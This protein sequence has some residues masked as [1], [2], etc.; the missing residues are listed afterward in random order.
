MKNFTFVKGILAFTILLVVSTE[1]AASQCQFPNPIPFYSQNFGTGA[2]P[3]VSPL[4]EYQVPELT[5]V[6][7]GNMNPEKI[8]TIS[9]TTNHH[10]PAS[11]WHIIADHTGNTQGRMMLVNDREPAGITYRDRLPS[12]ALGQGNLYFLSAWVMNILKPGICTANGNNPDIFISL[13]VDTKLGGVWSSLVTS[14]I[15]TY[16]S[17]VAPVWNRIGV[18]FTTPAG[19]YDSLRISINNESVVLCGNDYVVD[20]ISIVGC[21]GNIILPVKLLNFS[22]TLKNDVTT[23]NWETA[24]EVNFSHYE[25]E[26]RNANS[27]SYATVGT[28][29]LANSNG[30]AAYNFQDNLSGVSGDVFFYRLRM[31]DLDGSAEYSKEI[32]VRRGGKAL[33]GIA[34][35]PNPVMNGGAASV[36]FEAQR[37]ALVTLRVIDGTGKT[38]LQQ[39]NKV[40]EGTNSL[41]V[42]NIERLQPGIY[43]VQLSVG[44]ELSAVK[45]TV[46]R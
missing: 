33:S 25:I 18:N 27:G 14:P 37:S 15:F 29:A 32:L 44:D 30:R 3:A 35:N 36:R 43:V 38:V 2:R 20:D 46:V 16:P 10:S 7:T 9:S 8:Y 41:S 5:Y 45:F 23:L 26:R 39:Q 19:L 21:E 13:R 31:V 24:A 12:S 42:N 34:I 28:K 40:A 4:S 6:G 1:K 22:G 11:D 17:T